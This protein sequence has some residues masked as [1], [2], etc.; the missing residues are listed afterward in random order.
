[1]EIGWTTG[2]DESVQLSSVHLC[3]QRGGQCVEPVVG[4]AAALLAV[5]GGQ[6]GR[7]SPSHWASVL[8][9]AVAVAAASAG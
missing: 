8:I 3:V 5:Q 2:Q 1:M 6:G 4:S 9:C 7:P